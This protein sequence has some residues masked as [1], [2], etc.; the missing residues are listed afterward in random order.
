MVARP[1]I[2]YPKSYTAAG[3]GTSETVVTV[4][5]VKEK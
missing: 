3:T 5:D 1:K 4:R 2:A